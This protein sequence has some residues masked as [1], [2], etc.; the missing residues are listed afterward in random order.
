M[1][2]ELWHQ[3]LESYLALRRA[4]GFSMRPEE[5]L[6]RDFVTY[7]DKRR[8]TVAKTGSRP[9]LG[10]SITK[11]PRRPVMRPTPGSAHLRPSIASRAGR[12]NPGNRIV[13][14]LRATNSRCCVELSG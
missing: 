13:V 7:L 11:R 6:L 5:R 14:S 1:T 12:R 8:A 3:Q 10:R 2:G 9:N 4:L